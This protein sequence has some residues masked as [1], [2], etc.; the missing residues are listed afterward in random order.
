MR[1][2]KSFMPVS[3]WMLRLSLVFLYYVL[4]KDDVLAFQYNT[5]SFYIAL[6]F[7]IGAIGLLIG[8]MLS[9]PST[10]VL[11]SLLLLGLSVYKVI[12]VFSGGISQGIVIFFISA[13]VSL[14]FFAR[15]NQG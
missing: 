15:G 3:R 8:G 11:S 2:I 5:L 1:P 13:S 12:A 7:V 14:F 10:T 6:S 9:K 4:F